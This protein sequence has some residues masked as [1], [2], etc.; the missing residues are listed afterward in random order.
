MNLPR[1]AAAGAALLA[2]AGA[3]LDVMTARAA[4]PD[5]ALGAPSVRAA[6]ARWEAA[7]RR[8]R[9]AGLLPDV[10][11]GG[12]L[13]SKDTPADRY[14][15]WEV[16][17]QQPLPRAGERSADRQRAQAQAEMAAADF[18]MACG[19]TA[20]E[21]AMQLS[22]LV[23]AKGRVALL[24]SQRARTDQALAAVDRRLAAGQ[25][26]A[27]GRL[28]LAS[29]RADLD[30]M[31]AQDR[32]MAAEADSGVRVQLGLSAA[33]PLPD[34][35]APEM[36]RLDASRSP[37]VRAA[38]ARRREAEAMAAMARAGA[39]PM[40]AVGLRYEREDM[41]EGAEDTVGVAFMSEL[42]W[43]S[44]GAARAGEAAARDEV[45]AA[46]DQA[47]AA[48][49][50]AESLIATSARSEA[51]AAEARALGGET[52]RRFDA[53]YE[54]LVRKAG[55]DGMASDSAVLMLAELLERQ[56]EVQMR[57]LEAEHAA[58]AARARLWTLAPPA[59]ST[60]VP[61]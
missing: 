45:E 4:L 58:R 12:M 13:S 30:L 22:E 9:A 19:E 40:T 60:G 59:P 52:L 31:I 3:F 42:P 35:A 46:R 7:Q 37:S 57:V 8:V 54:A 33:D 32:Q 38:D 53:E 43:R 28:A 1:H 16:T 20:A 18:L 21:A 14:P 36:D 34:Y 51:V 29:R 11:A 23:R 25:G 5:A 15:M 10:Q 61:P 56:M 26:S 24:E 17:L 2:A 27:A 39:R 49:R 48:R 55:V 44:R 6:R 41:P 47:D 50:A